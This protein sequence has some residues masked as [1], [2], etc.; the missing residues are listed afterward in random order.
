MASPELTGVF[1]INQLFCSEPL[2]SRAQPA[3]QLL[4]GMHQG[5]PRGD[6]A[7]G[8]RPFSVAQ[9]TPNRTIR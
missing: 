2:H 7:R 8:T 3:D 1:F 4:V 6:E 5:A 9:A